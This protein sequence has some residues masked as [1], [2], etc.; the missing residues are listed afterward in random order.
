MRGLPQLRHTGVFTTDLLL[1]A[2]LLPDDHR[3]AYHE[4]FLALVRQRGFPLHTASLWNA[5]YFGWSLDLSGYLGRGLRLSMAENG[6]AIPVGAFVEVGLGGRCIALAEVVYKEGRDPRIDELGLVEPAASGGR[7]ALLRSREPQA[8]REGLVLDFSAFGEGLNDTDGKV[9]ARAQRRK[10]LT[11]DQHKLVQATYAPQDAGVDDLTLFAR[12]MLRQYGDDLLGPFLLD[13]G[14]GVSRE[15][16]WELLIRSLQAVDELAG[17]TPGLATFGFYHLDAEAYNDD[18]L[19]RGDAPFG[20]DALDSIALA[21]LRAPAEA[22]GQHRFGTNDGGRRHRPLYQATGALVR[23]YLA[24]T[25][26]NCEE[27]RLLAG[28]SYARLVLET[29]LSIARRIGED[30]HG[31]ES[32]VYVRLD[33]DREG[34]GIWRTVRYEQGRPPEARFGPLVPLGL[35]YSEATMSG[36]GSEAAQAPEPEPVSA[37]RDESGWRVPL[38]LVDLQHRHLVLTPEAFA[39]LPRDATDVIVDLGDGIHDPSRR[40]RPLDR[41]R[42]L[43]GDML[44]P[45]AFFAGIVLRYT[46]ARGGRLITVRATPLGAPIEMEGRTLRWEFNQRVF[47]QELRLLPLDLPHAAH[48]RSLS[49]LMAEAF[50]RRGRLTPD[51]GRALRADEVISALLGTDHDLTLSGPIILRLQSGDYAFR[52]GEYVWFPRL[53]LRT[54]PRERIRLF[55]SRRESEPRLRRILAPRM[56]QMTVRTYTKGRM[57]RK[58]ATYEQAL[59]DNHMRGLL[60]DSLRPNQTWVVPYRLG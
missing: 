11:E 14:A 17:E 10:L 50:G 20:A 44:Y 23:E 22:D 51:G 45:G 52:D 40:T 36:T 24:R 26:V 2:D 28:P 29:N 30:G 4:F 15:D 18:L 33:D 42:R 21:V 7:V 13:G 16:R 56:V 54:S 6:P 12:Y 58:H 48:Q 39:L 3:R 59:A 31:I 46:I 49:E 27:R 25:G 53:S 37:E 55:E 41:E 43:V 1:G 38:R 57:G 47:R 32:G 34:G 35:G 9:L 5:L 19:E 60:P 8:V